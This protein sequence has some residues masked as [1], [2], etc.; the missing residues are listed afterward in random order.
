MEQLPRKALLR[1]DEVAD[2]FQVT[3]RTI[4]LWIEHGLLD[5]EKI[6]RSIVRVKRES[7]AKCMIRIQPKRIE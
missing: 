3:D 6:N 5:A 4:R 1:V 7:I 2:Y